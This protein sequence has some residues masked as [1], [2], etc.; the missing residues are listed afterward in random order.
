M[1]LNT[2]L[3]IKAETTYGTP[4]TVDR[5]YEFLSEGIVPDARRIQ[6][7]GLRASGFVQRSDR[8][9]PY[10]VGHD[11]PISLEVL[12]KGY[13]LL[14]GHILG[15]VAT[16]GPTDSAYTHTA[17]VAALL[18]K[19]LTAQVNRTL[20]PAGTNQAF[21]FAGGKI[22]EA[23]L[24][25]DV[26]GVL[27]LDLALAFATATTA[28]AL[29]TASYPTGA[30]LLT[31]AGGSLTLGGSA[32]PTKSVSIKV[33]NNL[34]TNILRMGQTG[35]SQPHESAFRAVTWEAVCDFENLTQYNRVVASTP[36]GTLA[37]LVAAWVGPT[38]IG[39]ATYPS[40][41][42]TIPAARFDKADVTVAGQGTIEAKLSGTGLWNGSASPI[43][44]A[45][46]S[47]DATA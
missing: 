22:T 43:T 10:V 35:R 30:E 40:L 9:H 42:A 21:T 45:Y 2:Q 16:A 23:T 18:G 32:V 12:T 36:A 17:T 6:G 46:V 1:P 38:L 37:S 39:A 44:L 26:E 29:A 5:F 34:D 27:M 11:G 28:T 25:S 13:G 3:G 14:F 41:T 24:K 47:T 4:V 20:Y 8:F 33:A 19:G 7:A 31:W 15:D